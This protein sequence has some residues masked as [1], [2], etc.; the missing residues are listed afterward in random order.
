MKQETLALKDKLVSLTGLK[1]SVL[2]HAKALDDAKFSEAGLV[3]DKHLREDKS[4]TKGNRRDKKAPALHYYKNQYFRKGKGLYGELLPL[5]GAPHERV[6]SMN[7]S[8]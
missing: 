4:S 5:S 3:Q 1:A 8:F 6:A 7:A 2:S